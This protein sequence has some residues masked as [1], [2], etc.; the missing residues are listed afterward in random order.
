MPI[1]EMTLIEGYEP[2][3]KA[4]LAQQLTAAVQQVIPA[5]A[6]GTV[7]CFNEVA[8][9]NYWRGGVSRQGSA[10]L[11]DPV[12][13]VRRYLEAMEARD[14]ASARALLA[15][16]FQMQFPGPV[17]PPSLES[18][19]EWAATRYRFVRKTYEAWD[20]AQSGEDTIVICHGTLAG[21]WLD[22]RSFEGIRF[23]DRFVL[24]AGRIVEQKVWNDLA[25]AAGAR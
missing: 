15:P 22:G 24:R 23:L 14:L 1:V 17:S 7:V 25:I 19:V 18:L 13:L 6:D 20:C 16:E 5:P 8:P 3:V 11:P 9:G 21:E 4:R 12:A 2:E 10:A